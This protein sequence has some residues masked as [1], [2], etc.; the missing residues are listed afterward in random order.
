[1]EFNNW[2]ENSVSTDK[3]TEIAEVVGYALID[4]DTGEIVEKVGDIGDYDNT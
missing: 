2:K 4:N 1:M 3:M